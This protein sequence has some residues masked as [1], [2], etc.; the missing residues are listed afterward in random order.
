M[1]SPPRNKRGRKK[2]LPPPTEADRRE[3]HRRRLRNYRLSLLVAPAV[4]QA[5]LQ[6][7]IDQTNMLI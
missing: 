7:L 1:T 3:Y 2:R 4:A 5:L 6:V